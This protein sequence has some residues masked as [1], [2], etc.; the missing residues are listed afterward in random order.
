MAVPLSLNKTHF[1]AEAYESKEVVPKYHGILNGT[2][3]W[4]DFKATMVKTFFSA[5]GNQL[6]L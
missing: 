5:N 3:N 2:F 4:D 6:Q 1:L